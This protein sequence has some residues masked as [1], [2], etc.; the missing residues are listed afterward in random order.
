MPSK[1]GFNDATDREKQR[2]LA[3]E[4]Q[5]RADA[6]G[7]EDDAAFRAQITRINPIVRDVLLDLCASQGEQLVAGDIH[8]T[9]SEFEHSGYALR[10]LWELREPLGGK[11]GYLHIALSNPGSEPRIIAWISD[12]NRSTLPFNEPIVKL[13]Q[14]LKNTTDLS[15]RAEMACG[16]MGG[17]W[18][19]KHDV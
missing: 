15:A 9:L 11:F 3:A 10:V 19:L 4:R 2:A 13:A 8:M 16:W 5:Q 18:T 6:Q 17:S 7:R 14:V 1:Y 12:G